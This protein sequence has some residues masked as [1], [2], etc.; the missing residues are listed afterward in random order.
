MEKLFIIPARGGSKGIPG[1]N[2][3]PLCGKPLIHYSLEYAR[4]F[5]NDD[6]IC[7]TT[8]SEEIANSVAEL[9][10]QVPFLRP[11]EL[12]TDTAGSYEVILHALSYYELKKRYDV[13]VLLQP[14]S[15]FRKKLD[16]EEALKLFKPEI[17]MVVSVKL[18]EANPYYNLFEVNDK[19]FMKK[20]K[21]G[22]FET[23]Q[24]C[25]RVYQYNGS[26]YIFNP[27]SVKNSNINAFEKIVKYE[28]P[29]PYSLDLDTPEDW[30]LAECIMLL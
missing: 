1:K 19:G 30:K 12:A 23:R 24:E 16:L 28:M 14:T 11:K 2:I 10:Y 5:V 7:V 29:L 20:S 6:D 25:P 15:P 3:K 18:S 26:L 17:D 4:L 8:D 27:I 22:N 13:V 21:E 9:G